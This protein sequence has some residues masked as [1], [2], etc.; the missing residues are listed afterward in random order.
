MLRRLKRVDRSLLTAVVS[1]TFGVLSQLT[2]GSR[3]G[4]PIDLTVCQVLQ[5]PPSYR[6][7][8]VR[9]TGTYSFGLRGCCERPLKVGAHEWPSALSVVGTDFPSFGFPA[10]F[11]TDDRSWDQLNLV[12]A[13]QTRAHSKTE[14]V[15]TILGMIRAP[16][17]YMRSNGQIVGCYGHLGVFP[18]ELVVKRVVKISTK[19]HSPCASK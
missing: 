15:A 6:G 19:V 11:K 13:E 17:S 16:K 12:L 14:V 5:N 9:V 2:A 18:A 7:K 3:D 4:E 8:I 10:P 1:L